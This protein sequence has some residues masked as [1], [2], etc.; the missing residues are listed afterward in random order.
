MTGRASRRS[1]RTR[2]ETA[3]AACRS[4]WCP[5]TRCLR[6]T[7][8]PKTS[9]ATAPTTTSALTDWPSRRVAAA[10]ETSKVIGLRLERRQPERF[11]W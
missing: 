3:S 9:R 6:S 2:T 10:D 8:T 7:R 4:Y 5:G 11:L 1:A